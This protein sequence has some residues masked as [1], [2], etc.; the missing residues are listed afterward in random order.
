MATMKTLAKLR[1]VKPLITRSRLK[2]VRFVDHYYY[3]KFDYCW[4]YKRSQGELYSLK[5]DFWKEIPYSGA[6]DIH[7]WG[8]SLLNN[9]INEFYYWIAIHRKSLDYFILS[10]DF[11]EEKFSTSPVPNF[12]GSLEHHELELLDFNGLLGAFV[13]PKKG[14]EKSF[15]LWVMKN[16]SWTREFNIGPISGAEWPLG[17]WKNGELFLRGSNHDLLLFDPANHELKN[18]GIHAYTHPRKMQ[19]ITYTV[20]SFLSSIQF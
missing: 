20:P 3:D 11:A 9:H 15:D 1:A 12:S 4:P 14:A 19:L 13:F 6:R 2:V 18:L 7:F 5:S 8:Y 17:F 10:F 16:G